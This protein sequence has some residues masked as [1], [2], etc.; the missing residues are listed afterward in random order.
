MGP[1]LSDEYTG[2][3]HILGCAL[4]KIKRLR[5]NLKIVRRGKAKRDAYYALTEKESFEDINEQRQT[6]ERLFARNIELADQYRRR[7][8]DPLEDD[9]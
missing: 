6:V 8:A 2:Y 7:V 3:E 5:H 1:A 4:T 9:E